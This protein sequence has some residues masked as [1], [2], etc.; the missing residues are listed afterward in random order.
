M[1]LGASGREKFRRCWFVKG[2]AVGDNG[3]VVDVGEVGVI[4]GEE[5]PVCR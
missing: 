4:G 2:D 5:G 1:P 3:W